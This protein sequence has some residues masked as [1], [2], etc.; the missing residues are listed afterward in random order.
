MKHWIL[1]ALAL[2][3]LA[4]QAPR[5]WAQASGAASGASSAASGAAPAVPAQASGIVGLVQMAAGAIKKCKA[6]CCACPLG[7]MLSNAAKPLNTALGG[8]LCPPCCPPISDED[9]KKSSTSAQGACAKI[10]Q[11]EM[12]MPARRKAVQ[13]LAHA[14]CHWWPEA[15]AALIN[16]LRVDQ[17]ECIRLEAALVLG[18]GCCCTKK[19]IAA[20]LIVVTGSKKDGNPSENSERV[21]AAAAGALQHCLACYKEEDDDPKR[22][23]QPPKPPGP[24]PPPASSALNPERDRL[25]YYDR[26]ESVPSATLLESARQALAKSETFV[27]RTEMVSAPTAGRNLIQLWEAAQRPS[28]TSEPAPVSAKVVPVAQTQTPVV[29]ATYQAPSDAPRVRLTFQE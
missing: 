10:M 29:P 9:K 27:A 25:A 23:E 16:A 20:L 5:L 22:P 26:L 12:E 11:E 2:V 15:E 14:D 28:V 7:Q 6:K 13:C 21:K 3:V 4:G 18:S 24:P 17:N 19:T 8:L 1:S